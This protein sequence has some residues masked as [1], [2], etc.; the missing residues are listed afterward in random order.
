MPLE[1]QQPLAHDQTSIPC[2]AS[3]SNAGSVHDC[4]SARATPVVYQHYTVLTCIPFWHTA[5]VYLHPSSIAPCW[6][7]LYC[8]VCMIGTCCFQGCFGVLAAH[9]CAHQVVL[10][11]SHKHNITHQP[12]VLMLPA[13]TTWRR[14]RHQGL[15][16]MWPFFVIR[17]LESQIVVRKVG[18]NL[19]GN[20]VCSTCL[21]QRQHCTCE[22]CTACATAQTLTAQLQHP[23]TRRCPWRQLPTTVGPWLTAASHCALAGGGMVTLS[24]FKVHC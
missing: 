8:I 2:S 7:H 12:S 9:V 21:W 1:Q 17:L 16:S 11:V 3:G 19:V 6:V 23:W 14:N 24:G 10:H 13:H 22:Q 4:Q 18:L 15:A 20:K 5:H